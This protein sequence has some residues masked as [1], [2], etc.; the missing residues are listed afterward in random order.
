MGHQL[1]VWLNAATTELDRLGEPYIVSHN[2]LAGCVQDVDFVHQA[3]SIQGAN[4][5]HTGT[6]RTRKQASSTYTCTLQHS[7]NVLQP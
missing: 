1:Y 2:E 5:P 4:M 3:G 6:N 7:T